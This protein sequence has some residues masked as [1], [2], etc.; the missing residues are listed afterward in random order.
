MSDKNLN[1][2]PC[3]RELNATLSMLADN[4]A[5]LLKTLDH[6]TPAFYQ[7][8]LVACTIDEMLDRLQ[9]P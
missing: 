5:A 4:A 6:G 8:R 2:T 7:A 1:F 3:E 9:H